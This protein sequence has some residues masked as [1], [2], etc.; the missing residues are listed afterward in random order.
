MPRIVDQ[1]RLGAPDALGEA[2][3]RGMHRRPV[4]VAA[5]DD[6]KAHALELLGNIVRIISAVAE[7]RRRLVCAIANHERDTLFGSARLGEEADSEHETKREASDRYVHIHNPGRI[8]QLR[9]DF[10]AKPSLCGRRICPTAGL[11]DRAKSSSRTSDP[12]AGRHRNL[13]ALEAHVSV[14]WELPNV[15]YVSI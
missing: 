13:F 10:N 15:F 4:E 14:P 1:G 12:I 11:P 6:G 2:A 9:S 5:I 3:E 8:F 7:L